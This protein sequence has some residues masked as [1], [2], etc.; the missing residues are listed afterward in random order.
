MP[1]PEERLYNPERA[2]RWF[3]VSSV[4]MTASIGWMI[5]VDYARPWHGHQDAYAVSKATLAHLDYLDSTRQERVQQID[6]ARARWQDQL[7]LLQKSHGPKLESLREQLASADLA[8]RKANGPFSSAGQLLEVTRDRYEKVLGQFGESHPLTQEAH[9]NLREEEELVDGLRKDKEQWEDERKHV[10]A[11]IKRLE[12]GARDAEKRLRDLE[13]VAASA[14]Q[15]DQQFRGVLTDHGLL[16]GIPVVRAIINMPLLD[17]SSPK[18]TPGRYQV[19]QLVLPDVRQQLNYLESYTTD[20]C[21]TCHVGIADPEFSKDRLARKLERSLPGINEALQRMSEPPFEPPPPPVLEGEG[22]AP[23]PIGAVTEHWNEL[24]AA[25]Q[26]AYFDALLELVNR[27]LKLS[28]RKTI[29]LGQPLLAHPNLEL[30]VTVDSPHPMAKMGCTACHEGNPQE[31][32]FVLAAHSPPTHELEEQWADQYYVRRAGIPNSTFET[33]RHYWDRP[34]HVPRHTEASCAKCHTEIS[35]ITMFQGKRHGSRINLGRHLFTT[36][37]CVNCHV[38]D[39]LPGARK[40]GPDLSQVA[41]KLKPEFV[42]QWAYFPQKFRPST[43]MPHFFAQENN[44]PNSANQFDTRPLLRTETE[45]AAISQYLFAVSKDFKPL[46]KPTEVTGDSARGRELFRQVG[47]LGCHANLAEHGEE[48]I[49]RDLMHRLGLDE[50]TAAFRYKGMTYEERVRYAME[51][52]PAETESIFEPE[53][54]AFDPDKP[55]TPPVFSRVGP[56]L[57][58]VGSKVSFE[59]LYSWLSDPTRYAP[60]TKMPNLRLSPAEAADIAAYLMGLKNDAFQQ[61]AFELSPERRVMADDLIFSLLAAQRSERRSRAIMNDEGGELTR[62]LVDLIKGSLQQRAYDVV[63]GM[64]LEEKKLTF[65]GNKM[66]S[67]YGCYACHKI[68]GFEETTPPGTNLTTWAQKPVSQ[69][70]FAFYDDAFHHMRG[71]KEKVFGH[72]YPLYADDLN[73]WSPGDNPEEQITHTHAAF[74]KHKLR[75]P[76]IW[77]REKIKRPYD[78]LKMPNFYFTDREAEAL[79]TYLLSRVSPRVSDKLKIK[80]EVDALGPIARGRNLTRE[81]NCVGCH[82]IEENAPAIQ[83]YF[84]RKIGGR[85]AF[86]AANAPPLLWGEGAKVQH[87]WFHRFL[88]QVEPLRPWLA[89]RMPSFH[90]TGQQATGLV[91]YFAAL[92]RQDAKNLTKLLAPVAEYRSKAKAAAGETGAGKPADSAGEPGSGPEATGADW[93][94]QENLQPVA[95]TLRRWAVERRVMRPSDVDML[96]NPPER[97]RT[98]HETLL[99]RLEFI[100]GLYDVPYPFV[101]PP[102]PFSG[103]QRFE[104]GG[105]FFND[106]GCLKCHVFGNM[107]PG[108]A[109]TTDDFVQTYRLDGV[110]GEGDQA[111]AFLNGMPHPVGSVID[112]HTLISAANTYYDSGD[113]ETKAVVEGPGS[114]GEK[115]RIMLQ[116]ASAPNLALT[117]QRLRRQWVYQWMLEPQLIQP[118][119]KMPQNF[120]EGKSPYE[121]D[122][123]YPGTGADH[124]NLL[125]DYLYD[126]GAT[127]TRSPLPKIPAAAKAEEF[128]EEGGEKKKEEFIED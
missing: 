16:G 82:Q 99:R 101:E 55:Y 17:F 20:R 108:P 77:D 119:T 11:E 124:I 71:E 70:D 69:L 87:N 117:Y 126:A 2:N 86:D 45:V 115:E 121:G 1:I 127:N 63:S 19:N 84:R 31:T 36:V 43:L 75:N 88:Q 68:N 118:G 120:P 40:V 93:Y 26:N 96:R 122:A 94:L 73:Q 27:Y 10:E 13:Q 76:R 32:D 5:Y 65:L 92:S 23:L 89:V 107:L 56:E 3:A 46:D 95:T 100:R 125:V 44:G 48:W 15:K 14:L 62:M 9:R 6:E 54:A 22:K 74:A 8:F 66:I 110:R 103:A 112:G 24:T 111:V 18:G 61:R 7:T 72:L 64:S 41:A 106:M 25:Q 38:V 123:K 105:R 67:H 113:V 30:Y 109:K 52:F 51:H 50:Q 57:S 98:A 97:V 58:G 83:Q 29:K 49:T 116:A 47:C 53:K 114:G 34:M 90:V 37:G 91:E 28:G 85:L 102:R 21:T 78:K 12:A 35:D 33:V 60:D 59:W 128:D 39:D 42:Q 79:T 104:L 4:L 80:Y 81:L